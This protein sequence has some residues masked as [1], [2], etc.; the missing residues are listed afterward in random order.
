MGGPCY[1]S[2]F[3]CFSAVNAGTASALKK[4]GVCRMMTGRSINNCP[5]DNILHKLES[6]I[7]EKCFQG[8]E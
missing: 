4:V 3:G 2:C 8:A 5:N 7:R 6:G 1:W